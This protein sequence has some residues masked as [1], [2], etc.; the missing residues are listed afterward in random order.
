MNIKKLF[1]VSPLFL[2]FSLI[3]SSQ[4]VSPTKVWAASD[5]V[6]EV[7]YDDLVNELARK[8]NA[9]KTPVTN[10]LDT[11]KIHAGLGLITSANR[12][13][14]SNGASTKSQNGFQLS[15]GID[16]LSAD[17]AAEAALRNFGQATT[18]SES[19]TLREF[20]LKMMN[21][22]PL[23]ANLGYRWGAG[24]GTRY[25]KVQDDVT[26]VSVNDSTPTALF[27]GG[28]D[29]FA[30]KNMSLGLEGG[31]RSSLMNSTADKGSADLM[32]RFDTYF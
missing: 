1:K 9:Y 28:V 4:L 19:R 31:L 15:V 30:N 27:F 5:E 29:V 25:L 18:G 24:L 3:L 17:W 12:I 10:P 11:L 21:R 6:K 7:S 23:S 26:G 22:G 2:T 32:V 16:L 8:K 20:D 14:T 13:S